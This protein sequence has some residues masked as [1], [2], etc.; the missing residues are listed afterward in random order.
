[1]V[2]E[3]LLISNREL[4]KLTAWSSFE[5]VFDDII[6]LLVEQTK[7]TEIKTR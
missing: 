1:M 3:K 7:Q 6:D 4:A 5:L 2:Q